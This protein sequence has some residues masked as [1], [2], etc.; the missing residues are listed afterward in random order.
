M[1]CG[2]QMN[3]HPLYYVYVYF[4]HFSTT[5]RKNKYQYL[6]STNTLLFLAADLVFFCYLYF[7]NCYK[8]LMFVLNINIL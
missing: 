5:K 3:I 1:K 6:I 2:N 8:C 7:V 4:L